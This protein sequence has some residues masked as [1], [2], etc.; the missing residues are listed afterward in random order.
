MAEPAPANG[1]VSRT[2]PGPKTVVVL[3]NPTAG[4]R[5]GGAA[6]GELVRALRD[7]DLEPLV[8]SRRELLADAVGGREDVRCV[9][10]AGG[11]GTLA[12]V[13]NRVPGVPTAVL[14]L[15]NENLVARHFGVERSGRQLAEVIAGGRPRPLDLG[16]AGDRVFAAMLGVGFDAEVVHHVHR[17]RC[18]QIN[19]LSYVRPI[20]RTW[21]SYAFPE[22]N[23]EILDTS[24][25]LTG[26]T[27]FV[28]NLPRYGLGLPIAPWARADDGLLDLCV[29]RRPGRWNLLRY[30]LACTAR[31][32]MRLAD[33]QHRRVR[34]VRLSA[35]G[36]VP[37]Q[38]DGDPA[39]FLP[40]DVTVLPGALTLLAP[41]CA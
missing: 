12:E 1:E 40:A 9:V 7:H 29:F 23:V 33:F 2:V 25:R 26:A 32:Q 5:P 16:R 6:V 17:D 24:E 15:G 14:P 20:L 22:I 35:Q 3:V 37:L 8:C 11:D 13:L 18:G 30:L 41:D 21:R 27:V 10:A 4:C 39:G 31:R 36:P 38:A 28:F 19:K 34:H